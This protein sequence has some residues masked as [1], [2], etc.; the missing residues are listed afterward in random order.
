VNRI[1]TGVYAGN[2]Q[3]LSCS[4]F[5]YQ[6]FRVYS[7]ISF[8]QKYDK[9]GDFIRHFVPELKDFPAK[10]IYAPWE[11]PVDAQRK[12][13]CII[14]V[15]YPKPIVDHSV[16]MTQNKAR[17]QKAYAQGKAANADA[18]DESDDSDSGD[19]D[20]KK[21]KR[22]KADTAGKKTKASPAKKRKAS[23]GAK[24]S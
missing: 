3:W 18:T 21:S 2:W 5:F 10:Y 19:G 11:A 24:T 14:G 4:R 1:K 7:P 12:A 15:D 13:K 6:Y 20:A 23:S 9:N 17:M 16:A 8:A 22:R